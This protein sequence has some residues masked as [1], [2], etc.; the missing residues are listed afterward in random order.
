MSN[1]PGSVKYWMER[2]EEARTIANRM[3]D[4]FTRQTMIGIAFSYA[5][6]ALHTRDRLAELLDK[7]RREGE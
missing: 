7:E 5:R 2:A 6:L 4:P 3:R 1:M